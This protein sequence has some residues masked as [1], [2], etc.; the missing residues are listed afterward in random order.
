MV[1]AAVAHQVVA[2][3]PRTTDGQHGDADL[4]AVG[5]LLAEPARC[6][7]LLALDDGRALPAG[8]LAAEAGVSAATASRHLSR[9][10]GGGLVVVEPHG[11][12][13]Y[14]RL[15]GPGVGRLIE[16]VGA[17]APAL[18]VRSLRQGTRARALRQ[19]RTCYDH[20]AGRLGVALMASMLDAGH[21]AGGD[22]T[23]DPTRSTHDRLSAPGRDVDYAL[24]DAGRAF[25]DDLGVELPA[26]RRT[27]GYCVDWT[28]QR[29]HL[30]GGV[31]HG[32]L[33][34]LTALG[35]VRRSAASRAV[36]VTAAG[37]VGL[38]DRF[39]VRLD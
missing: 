7:M 39:D 3:E 17:L 18:P 20:L 22:G 38:A 9:L 25:L 31:G 8:R 26:R 27:V 35:W 30:A 1:R 13:R 2:V 34:R 37:R 15:A 12:L 32:L 36:D 33:T 19:A 16:V 23:F 5:A 11:R 14:F 24:T 6:R 29:H 21:L 4:A 10:V 28:E